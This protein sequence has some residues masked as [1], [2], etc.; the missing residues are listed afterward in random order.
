M[1]R[2]LIDLTGQRFVRLL[3]LE[4]VSKGSYKTSN[5][6][7]KCV[8][9]CG[10]FRTVSSSNLKSGKAKSCGCLRAEM[11]SKMARGNKFKKSK[12]G[13]SG[14]RIY[15]SWSSMISRCKHQSSGS[16]KDYGG[17]GILVCDRWSDHKNGFQN[18]LS[19]MGERPEGM[20]L[21]RINNDGNYEPE[22]CR[23]ATPK[24][25]ISNRRA[26]KIVPGELSLLFC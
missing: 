16:Y 19:D 17:R 21:D 18:F 6:M 12:H 8:C 2:K 15:N 1:A 9:D 10:H 7:W 3:V 20:T 23:W 22:N 11:T 4:R 24:E 26:Y 14:S 25:Q 5:S 13:L